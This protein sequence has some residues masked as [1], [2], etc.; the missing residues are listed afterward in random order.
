MSYV[1]YKEKEFVSTLKCKYPKSW[2]CDRFDSFITLEYGQNYLSPHE[3]RD[4]TLFS[5]QTE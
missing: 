4:C 5:G 3:E 1:F 2:K